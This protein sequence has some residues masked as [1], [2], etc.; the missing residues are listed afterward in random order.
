MRMVLRGG[1]SK[2]RRLQPAS[3]RGILASYRGLPILFKL[4]A[5]RPPSPGLGLDLGV[6]E[7]PGWPG[8]RQL[9]VSTCWLPCARRPHLGTPGHG[10]SRDMGKRCRSGKQQRT[11]RSKALAGRLLP[12]NPDDWQHLGG[13]HTALN[14]EW[15][16]VEDRGPLAACAPGARA[17]R[18]I[19]LSGSEPLP[20]VPPSLRLLGSPRFEPCLGPHLYRALA[21]RP[22]PGSSL[23]ILTAP[24]RPGI[25]GEDARPQEAAATSSPRASEPGP[26]VQQPGESAAPGTSPQQLPVEH[27]FACKECGAAFRLKVLL[28]QHQRV[29]SEE[30]GWECGDCG[31][32]FRGVAEFNEHRQSHVAA[33]PRP[34]PSRAAGAPETGEQMEREAKPFACEECGRRFKKNA[35]LS[36]HL[37]VHSREKPLACEECGRGFKA[38]Q[39]LV[40][41]GTEAAAS[42]VLA[43]SHLAVNACLMRRLLFA[44]M[45]RHNG[46]LALVRSPAATLSP[47]CVFTLKRKILSEAGPRPLGSRPSAPPPREAVEMTGQIIHWVREDPS[48]LGHHCPPP[49]EAPHHPQSQNWGLVAS[50]TYKT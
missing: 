22:S 46:P 14:T 26:K 11:T 3:A 15:S 34:G 31:R 23:R 29:H 21:A 24:R 30:K 25:M 9:D 20:A 5:H 38:C 42:P 7:W 43:E 10:Q 37:R 13:L 1:R 47:G 12:A 44:K 18:L 35:G 32:V 28:V 49:L 27:H 39:G 41:L 19:V 4:R 8:Q 2:P 40:A 50:F 36:Q 48:G 45:L 33:E 6:C 17:T 16:T